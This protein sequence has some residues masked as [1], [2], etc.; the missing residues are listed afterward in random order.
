MMPN[1]QQPVNA[2]LLDANMRIQQ[3]GDK[4]VNWYSPLEKPFHIA[5]FGW[6]HEERLYRRLPAQPDWKLPE[7]VDQ[8]A[9]CTAGGQIRFETNA[10]S[11]TVKV[12]LSGTA[13]MYHMTATGQCGFDCYMG[14]PGEQLYYGTTVYDHTQAEYEAVIFKDM[15]RESRIITLNFPLY[16]GVEEV[17]IGLERE[18]QIAP[19]PA[20]DNCGKI[21]VY[22]TSIT[23]GGCAARPGMA[24]TNI[25]SRRINREF[26]NLGFSGNGKG[27]PELAHILSDIPDPACLILDYEA[28]CVS[29]ELLQVTLP[30]FISIYRNKHPLTPILVISRIIYAKDKFHD[31][32]AQDRAER[33]Q[34]QLRTVEQRRELGDANIYFYDGS[35]LLGEDAHEC[36]VDGVHPTDL[37]FLRMANGL[38]PVLQ[39]IL[40][41]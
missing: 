8:L 34:F 18:D 25:L 38:A 15:A 32:M 10:A 7:A 5:G 2:L 26:L 1:E 6:L 16:Q 22:G 3:S 40:S 11:L 41:D 37:G 27:E 31:Q 35:N 29:T 30:E 21:I 24:Y 13:N 4:D 19:P 39:K 14:G 20:Y 36:T 9:N 23:Q 33:K 28:N 17:W 12:K